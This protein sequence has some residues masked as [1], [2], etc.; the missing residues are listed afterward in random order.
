MIYQLIVA[1]EG[2]WLACALGGDMNVMGEME[3][4]KEEELFSQ[5]KVDNAW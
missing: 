5:V 1:E 4:G 3:G 2:V